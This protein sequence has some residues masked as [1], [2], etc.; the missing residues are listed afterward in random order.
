MMRELEIYDTADDLAEAAARFI[1]QVAQE[2]I[3]ARGKFTLAFTGGT[4]PELLY[5]RLAEAYRVDIDWRFL[6]AYW[7]D[8]RPVPPD[9]PE[10]NYG[11][12]N[13]TLLQHVSIPP[14][15]IHRMK[16][17]KSPEGAMYEYDALLRQHLGSVPTFDLILLGMGD[18]GHCASLFPHTEALHEQY[19]W[20]VPNPVPKLNQTRL[21][22]TYPVLNAASCVL[23]MVSGDKKAEILKT[24]LE[25][26]F[27]PDKWPSQGVL[28][29]HG[30]LLWWVDSAAAAHLRSN[31]ATAGLDGTTLE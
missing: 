12:A 13:R 17:E 30:R 25:G 18:D 3:E 1:V 10:S 20:A 7:G 26:P 27:D 15:Q 11:M 2:S 4:T 6:H 16:G 24:V 31:A 14:E 9:H 19:R 21:T 8:E 5:N 29:E 23:F 22:L 28:P